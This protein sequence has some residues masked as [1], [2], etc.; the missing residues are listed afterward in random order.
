MFSEIWKMEDLRKRVLFTLGMLGI[1]RMGIFVPSP[2]IDRGAL[3]TWLDQGNDSLF[4]LYNMF[5]GG[6]LE[7][8]SIFVLG[9]M[10]Y[11]TASIIMQL[12][13]EMTPSLKRLKEEGQSG[14]NK[15]TQYTRYMTIGIAMFQSLGIAR[16]LESTGVGGNDVVI[17]PGWGFRLM[18]MLTMTAGACF[19]MWLGEQMTERGVGNGASILITAGIIAGLPQGAI[20]LLTQVQEGQIQLIT[21]VMF[22]VFMFVVMFLIVFIER[23]QRRIP[24]RHAKRVMGNTVYEGQTT[25]LPLKVNTAGVIPP[26]FASSFLMVPSTLG[27][28][29]QNDAV[30]LIQGA[31]YPGRWLYNVTFTGLIVFFS[32][33]YTAFTVNPEDLADNLKKQGGFIPRVRPGRETTAYLDWVLTRLTAGGAIYLAAVSLMPIAVNILFEMNY[34][35]GGTS[36]LILVGV[37]LDTV[38]QIQAKLN[39]R[40]YDDVG[41]PTGGR[42]RGRRR[43]IGGQGPFG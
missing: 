36:L 18:T 26:I 7:Q 10:P 25:Y 24:L 28:F 5:T 1:Y 15:I 31:L 27:Q 8:Y 37:C 33:F 32:F 3:A 4:G 13:A 16:A 29:Y 23:G 30:T 42:I 14:Q 6:A 40:H 11:I 41:G 21:A 12:M 43:Q 17:S 20:N 2:G 38:G 34:F 35:F 9:I 39:T 22:L 19:V